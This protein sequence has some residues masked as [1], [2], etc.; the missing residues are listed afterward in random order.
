MKLLKKT[1]YFS[2]V[3]GAAFLNAACSRDSNAPASPA[4]DPQSKT[5]PASWY[6]LPENASSPA[7][8]ETFHAPTGAADL[9]V[10][11]VFD[12]T[13]APLTGD[14]ATS[15]LASAVAAPAVHPKDWMPWHLD[16]MVPYFAV[17][18]GGV[19]GAL[20]YGGTESV[21][22]T[23][24]YKRDA[25]P[26][27]V[28]RAK[29]KASIKVT[30]ETSLADLEKQLEPTVQMA[31]RSGAVRDEATLRANLRKSAAQF[32]EM[33]RTLDSVKFTSGWYVDG[34]QLNLVVTAS[35]QI[36]PTLG[37]G[38]AINVY[39]DW[40]KAPSAASPDAAVASTPVNRELADLVKT[41]AALI[42][43][44]ASEA[45]GLKNDGFGLDMIQ[46][47]LG[48]TAGG[49]IGIVSASGGA[50]GRVIF[51]R[52]MATNAVLAA[53]PTQLGT[54]NLIG[55]APS[56]QQLAFAKASGI[57]FA[58][59]SVSPQSLGQAPEVVYRV[60]GERLRA[61]LRK[62]IRM[63]SYFTGKAKR[64]PAG[65]YQLNQLEAEFDTSL[66][67]DLKLAVVNG[68]GQFVLDFDRVNP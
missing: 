17:S 61:G 13:V 59:S 9:A 47:G 31:V 1:A 45:D 54:V 37:V 18:Q 29:H 38:G 41:V 11:R 21:K 14:S 19:F 48:A 66:G 15:S 28:V 42:P 30:G 3:A 64:A 60:P 12:A 25:Q 8:G 43:Q 4:A 67:G 16:G 20:L 40:T 68:I 2:L 55:R 35:G 39:Y 52:D 44:A 49:T 58:A 51:K 7:G 36:T 57:P 50:I 6:E 62:A 5:L 56:A 22:G 26:V 46:L 23:W 33:S 65:H 53:E 32:L 24:Q 63:A 10:Q 34:L 27:N